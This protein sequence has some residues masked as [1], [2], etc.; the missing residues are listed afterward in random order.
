MIFVSIITVYKNNS[1][2]QYGKK[3]KYKIHL[4]LAMKKIFIDSKHVAAYNER[5]IVF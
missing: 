4:F 5:F 1:F 2:C 3:K